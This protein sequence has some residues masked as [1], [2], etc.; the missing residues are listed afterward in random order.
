MESKA[1]TIMLAV[2][3]IFER[4]LL[5]RFFQPTFAR[6]EAFY[7]HISFVDHLNC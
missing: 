1:R 5:I 7:L 2:R 4:G 6:T 3:V